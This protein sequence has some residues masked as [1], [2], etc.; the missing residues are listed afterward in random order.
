MKR[1]INRLKSFSLLAGVFL[2][3]TLHVS[4]QV[5]YSESFDATPFPPNGWTTTGGQSLWVQRTNGTNPTCTPH[6][7]NAMARFTA[8]NQ[9]PGTQ[10]RFVSPVVDFSGNA[11]NM[12]TFSLWVYR[13]G[14]S[15]AGDSVS[16]FV[17]TGTTLTGSTRIG[18]VA[19]SRFFVLPINE[20]A[21]GWY[22]YTFNVPATFNTDTNYFILNGTARGGGNIYIDDVSWVAYPTPCAGMPTAGNLT[23]DR[24]LICGGGG[25]A[26][27]TLTGATSGMSGI[28]YE[29]QSGSSATGPWTDFG[30]DATTA[31]TGNLSITTYFRC[32]VNC[33]ASGMA[34]TSNVV[35]VTIS[36]SAVPVV[37]V[38]P[39]NNVF[40]C[41]NSAPLVIVANGATTYTWTPDIAIPNGVGDSALAAPTANTTYTIVGSDTSGCSASVNLTITVRNSP[42][43]TGTTNNNTICSGQS[44]NLSASIQGPGFGIQYQWNPGPLNG[45]NQTVSPTNTTAYVVTATSPQS[46][47][48]GRD[49]VLIT[50]NPSNVAAFTYTVVNQTVTF[51]NGSTGATSWVW[52]FGDGN[53]STDQNPVYTYAS[54]GVY[55][56]TLTVQNGLCPTAVI[57]QTIV[58]GPAGIETLAEETGMIIFP[59]PTLGAI[60]LVFQSPSNM[61]QIEIIDLLGKIVYDNTVTNSVGSIFNIKLNLE[62]LAKGTYQVKVLTNDMIKLHRF[63]KQ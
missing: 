19:R 35:L 7:G 44:T 1:L 42:N 33:L 57:T 47:C 5:T 50:V 60:D 36:T 15:T 13:D 52:D 26:I 49:T 54:N 6:S 11:G 18:G 51:T 43:V 63:V 38:S 29:W 9:N 45:A 23:T 61:A 30:P 34:D 4:A 62:S 40:Y 3:A 8:F 12:P 24:S 28:S 17:N 27:L 10:D 20:T 14:N 21:D 25:D 41:T 48:S 58:V 59:N 2:F 56:V 37:T 22:E 46:G 32:V 53:T 39:N 55:M 16:I 31:N